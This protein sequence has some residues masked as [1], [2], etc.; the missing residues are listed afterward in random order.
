MCLYGKRHFCLTLY[1]ITIHASQGCPNWF[2]ALE[3]VLYHYY[4]FTDQVRYLLF[5][6]AQT[7]NQNTS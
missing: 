3:L 4:Q 7:I 2:D 5:Y 6:G 1:T